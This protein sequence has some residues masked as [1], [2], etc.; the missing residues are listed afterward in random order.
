MYIMAENYRKKLQE[1]DKNYYLVMSEYFNQYPRA[2][3]YPEIKKFSKLLEEDE[4]NLKSL[5]S[6][7]FMFKNNLEKDTKKASME[8]YKA[9]KLIAKLDKDNSKFKNSL[10]GINNDSL[11]A[12]GMFDDSQA[13]YNQSLL[14]NA[15]LTTGLLSVAVYIYRHR[16]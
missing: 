10:A 13:M 14:G 16:I 4:N 6:D 2:K 15:Y 1:L 9:D 5:Q 11:G 8:I 3:T 12:E 7:F